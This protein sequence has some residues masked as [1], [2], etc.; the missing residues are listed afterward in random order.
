MASRSP[1][2]PTRVNYRTFGR[3][4]GRGEQALLGAIRQLRDPDLQA[5]GLAQ[6]SGLGLGQEGCDA[7]IGLLPLLA[8]PAAPIDLL[9]AGSP[10]I[11]ASELDLLVCLLRIAQ[12]RHARPREDDTLAPLR[13]QLAR[14]AMAVQAA[15]LPLRQR[16]LSPVGLRLLDPTGWLRQR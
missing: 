3:Q 14:C 13:R 2:F 5:D 1:L 6:L 4:F 16:S 7:F 11:A 10:F 12:W 8:T 15:N 9:P